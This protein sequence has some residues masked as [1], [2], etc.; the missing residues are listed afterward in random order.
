MTPASK[1]FFQFVESRFQRLFTSRS[2]PWGAAPGWYES[3]LLALN[4]HDGGDSF[5]AKGATFINS[6][7]QRPKVSSTGKSPA[8]KARFI[9]EMRQ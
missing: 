9:P 6:L 7:G 4:T 3:A 2:K 8:L 5:S 1:P